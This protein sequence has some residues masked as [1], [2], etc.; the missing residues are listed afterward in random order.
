MA[1][2]A[3]TP[4]AFRSAKPLRLIDNPGDPVPRLQPLNLRIFWRWNCQLAKWS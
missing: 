3:G 1:I 2:D 4:R